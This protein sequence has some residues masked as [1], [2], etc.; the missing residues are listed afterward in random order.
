MLQFCKLL[1]F[2]VDM[3][4]SYT[5][6]VSMELRLSLVLW[7]KHVL[8]SILF[9]GFNENLNLLNNHSCLDFFLFMFQL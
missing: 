5:G 2:L 4:R 7:N 3:E 8:K 1:V 6:F 9:S